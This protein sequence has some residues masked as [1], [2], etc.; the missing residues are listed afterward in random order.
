MTKSHEDLSVLPSLDGLL[1]I[2]D[3]GRTAVRLRVLGV[4]AGAFHVISGMPG[5]PGLS[6]G[7]D[8]SL[9]LTRVRPEDLEAARIKLTEACRRIRYA[10]EALLRP[11]DMARARDCMLAEAEP[12]MPA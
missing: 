7:Q 12:I 9:G 8:G 1:C 2:T 5:T 6:V 11:A 4:G 3:C 10:G